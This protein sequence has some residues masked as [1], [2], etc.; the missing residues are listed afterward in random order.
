MSPDNLSKA[1]IFCRMPKIPVLIWKKSVR[2]QVK[3]FAEYWKSVKIFPRKKQEILQFK[4][5]INNCLRGR[6]FY[7]MVT[8]V[9][10]SVV[11]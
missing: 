5:H 2:G 4:E 8:K 6:M 11:I 1:L 3:F 10:R 9:P 7:N